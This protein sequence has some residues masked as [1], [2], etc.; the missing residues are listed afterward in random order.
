[1]N[2]AT[3][4]ECGCKFMAPRLSILLYW[5]N[6]VGYIRAIFLIYGLFIFRTK[7]LLGGALFICSMLL[8][9]L[10][11]FLARFLHQDSKFGETLDYA[12]DR[13][14]VAAF[15]IIQIL[16]YPQ[17]AFIF[18]LLL[19]LDILAHFFHLKSTHL[20][21]KKSH[22]DLDKEMS[23]PLRI[24]YANRWTLTLICMFHDLFFVALY[25]HYFSPNLLVTILGCVAFPVFV[26][27]TIIH[28]AKIFSASSVLL[29]ND[30]VKNRV[31]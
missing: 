30:V 13:A 28:I 12:L 4:S 31:Q 19:Q 29:N 27:K 22:K 5:P 23:W 11:G 3:N 17:Y 7:P 18:I 16:L 2:Q 20:Q 14:A 9:M 8:D 24:Y 15:F 25:F 1:M 26:L 10:D 6:I 21:N